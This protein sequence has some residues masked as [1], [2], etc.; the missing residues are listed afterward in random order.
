[1]LFPST[2]HI[3]SEINIYNS[4]ISCF[5]I[6]L[7]KKIFIVY[8]GSVQIPDTLCRHYNCKKIC[9]GLGKGRVCVLSFLSHH[10]IKHQNWGSCR[11]GTIEEKKPFGLRVARFNGKLAKFE[12]IKIIAELN[13]SIEKKY[14]VLIEFL[15]R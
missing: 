7:R 9:F 12:K 13:L 1:L 4:L 2:D 3:C 5:E 15:Q 10:V 14:S 6:Y 11:C 8:H